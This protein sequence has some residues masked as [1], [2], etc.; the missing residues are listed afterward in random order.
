VAE[1]K[2]EDE[3]RPEPASTRLVVE[4]DGRRRPFM[5]G[6]MVHSL[7]ERGVPFEEACSNHKLHD[8]LIGAEKSFHRLARNRLDDG[9]PFIH[10]NSE[11]RHYLSHMFVVQGV[12]GYEC[13]FETVAAVTELFLCASTSAPALEEKSM[14][15]EK[16]LHVSMSIV[17][18]QVVIA[19]GATVRKHLERHFSALLLVPLVEM[20]HPRFHFGLTQEERRRRLQPTISDVRRILG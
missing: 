1:Q 5:R 16:Y 17:K 6:I 9:T 15:A 4:E 8:R 3:P 11:E 20:E 10:P 18:P 12:F 13:E 19:V 2:P 7:M 14:C